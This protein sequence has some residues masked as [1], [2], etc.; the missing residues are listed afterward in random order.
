MGLIIALED[1]QSNRIEGIEDP[2]N[3]LHRLLPSADDLTSR[4]LKYVDWYGD[5]VFNRLQMDDLLREFQQ[6]RTGA[7][8]GGDKELISRIMVLAE[9]CKNEPHL[10]LKF[11]GD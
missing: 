8:D 11:Y 4:V 7:Q 6:I 5:T 9:R 10:Y 2:G 3:R 1:E